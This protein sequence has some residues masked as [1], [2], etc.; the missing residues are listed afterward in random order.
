MVSIIIPTYNRVNLILETL[1]SIASQTFTNWECIIVDDGSTDATEELVN[2][3]VERDKR[4]QFHRRP[5]NKLQGANAARNYGFKVS[6]GDFIQFF[7]S[8]DLMHS[9]HLEKKMNA[10]KLN[11]DL[12]FCT[13]HSQNFQ[14]NFFEK[15]L[16]EKSI[17][18]PTGDIYEDYILGRCSILMITPTWKREVLLKFELF[19]EK[20]KQ[21]QDM[22]L[23][24]RILLKYKNI[25]ILPE[26]LI[27]VRRNNDSISTKKG[28]LNIHLDSYL[29][30]KKRVL[31]LTPENRNIRTAVIKMVL[32]VFRYKLAAK[33]YKDCQQCLEFIDN[34]LDDKMI[35]LKYSMSRIKF[36]YYIFRIIGR[37]DTKFKRLLKI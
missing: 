25:E 17:N 22:E 11:S 20:L 12:H 13:C 31:N 6:K 36:F 7:D 28:K 8:D 16:G 14:G 24:S 2:K 3:Y 37:G 1:D 15:K 21:S 9:E 30:V 26:T 23:Y 18:E 32:G 33:E 4:F 34:H 5:A 29:E 19:D 10:F 35:Q 27:Y